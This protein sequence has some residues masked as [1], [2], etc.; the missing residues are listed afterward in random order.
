MRRQF[1]LE[2][3]GGGAHNI[4]EWLILIVSAR[5]NQYP[6]YS[7]IQWN[8]F[9]SLNDSRGIMYIVPGRMEGFKSGFVNRLLHMCLS[10]STK[11][12]LWQNLQFELLIFYYSV[13]LTLYHCIYNIQKTLLAWFNKYTKKTVLH[14]L[15][16][17]TANLKHT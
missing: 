7:R 3:G 10:I 1:F 13:S 14:C 5:L 4:L 9:I 2:G 12:T 16:K 8:M 6:G 15:R 17:Y 11:K